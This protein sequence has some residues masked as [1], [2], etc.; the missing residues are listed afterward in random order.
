MLTSRPGTIESLIPFIIQDMV[1]VHERN[2]W[3]S[4]IFAAQ[5]VIIIAIGFAAP[6]II[7]NL[8]W[9]WVYYL[10]AAVAAFFLSGVFIFLPETKWPRTKAELS[11]CCVQFIPWLHY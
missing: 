6:W 11:E 5:G 10:T 7:I 9:R 2:T 8:S 1:F 3:I 4:Y